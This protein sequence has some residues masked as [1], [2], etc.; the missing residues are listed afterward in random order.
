ME[1]LSAVLLSI[2]GV[3]SRA[4]YYNE[5]SNKWLDFIVWD[6][7]ENAHLGPEEAI[8][9]PDASKAFSMM[10]N[11]SVNLSYYKQMG[12]FVKTGNESN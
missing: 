5:E 9:H 10:D 2:E 1:N 12:G 11:E 4:F 6:T 3:K 7:L 8:K